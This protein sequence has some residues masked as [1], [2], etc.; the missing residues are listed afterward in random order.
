MKVII[1][2]ITGQLGWALKRTKPKEIEIIPC[3]RNLVDLKEEKSIIKFIEENNPDWVINCAAYTN[4]DKAEKEKDLA[5]KI[6]GNAPREIAKVL[7]HIGGH[8]LQISTDFVFNGE[9]NTPYKTTDSKNPVNYYGYSKALGEDYILDILDK[10][11]QVHILRTSWLMGP[12]GNNFALKIL[13]LLKTKKEINVVSDQIGAPTSTLNLAKACWKI[14]ENSQNKSLDDGS[15]KIL[16][17]ANEG[18][19][20]WYD[21]AFSIGLIANKI[22]LINNKTAVNPIST[23]NFPTAAIRPKYSV[24]DTFSTK[25]ILNLNNSHWMKGLDNDLKIFKNL[26]SS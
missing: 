7:N 12:V 5:I 4:V 25:S 22:G 18:I 6:N 19:A 23:K 13:Q 10:N 9:K 8:L 15:D 16:H 2:G 1:T 26:M 17:W 24:L 21:I 11:G 3:N 20:S 14:L